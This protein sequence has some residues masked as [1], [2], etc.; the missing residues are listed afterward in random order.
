MTRSPMADATSAATP[1]AARGYLDTPTMGLPTDDSVAAIQQALRDWSGGHPDYQRWEQSSE[2]CRRSFAAL[3][4]VGVDRVGLVPSVV[5]AVASAASGLDRGG[6]VVAHVM[7]FRSLL[8]PV[9]ATIGEHRIRWVVG[10]Y[11]ADTFVSGITPD[12]EAVLVSSASSHDGGRPRLAILLEAC[13]SVGAELF[14]DGTQTAGITELDV[15]VRDLSLFACAGYKGLRGPRGTGYAVMNDDLAARAT[16]R[17]PYGAA[18]LNH[19][20]YGPPL[21]PKSGAAGLDQSP[22]WFSWV[23]AEPALKSLLHPQDP[24]TTTP[25]ALAE[26]LRK[27]LQDLGLVPQDTDLPSPIVSFAIEDPAGYVGRLREGGLRAAARAGRIRIGFHRY[28]DEKDVELTVECLQR[29][30]AGSSPHHVKET[31]S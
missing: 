21:R 8:L 11:T 31:D 27:R 17:S 12:T 29:T 23:G 25:T 10:P 2:A 5:P 7:E 24:H 6:M 20:T 9:L 1:G 18:D 30:R 16:A 19:G 4:G 13:R 26:R 15:A 14:V 3:V 28:N 22:A